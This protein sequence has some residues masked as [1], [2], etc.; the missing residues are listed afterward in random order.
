M[1]KGGRRRADY[2]ERDY[3]AGFADD[4]DTSVTADRGVYFSADGRRRHEE[5]LNVAHKKRRLK[6]Q[7]LNDPLGAWIPVPEDQVDT[8]AENDDSET[9]DPVGGNKRK[10]YE[11][12][13]S[14]DFF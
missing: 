12:S 14:L 7:N 8:T 9:T 10:R 1:N 3:D 11:G 4:A 2:V 13:V 6:P 5:L